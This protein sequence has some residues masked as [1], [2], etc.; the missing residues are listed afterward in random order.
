MWPDQ[1]VEEP[2]GQIS[3]LPR[4]FA[5][6]RDLIRTIAGR[7]YQFTGEIRMVPS[8]QSDVL[9]RPVARLHSVQ[10]LGAPEPSY[11]QILVTA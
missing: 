11:C 5:T 10:S 8:K 2:P 6:D 3:A 7:G 4:A 9:V 1:I